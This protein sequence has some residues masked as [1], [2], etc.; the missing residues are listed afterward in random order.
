MGDAQPFCLVEGRDERL[1]GCVCATEFASFVDKWG[2]IIY[3][4]M[5]VSAR[6]AEEGRRVMRE[7][8][9]IGAW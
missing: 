4:V 3:T 1:V 2:M 7:D 8:A 9:I 6:M 5:Q